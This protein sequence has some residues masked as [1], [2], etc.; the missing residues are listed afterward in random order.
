M[1]AAGEDLLPPVEG[2]QLLFE[3]DVPAFGEAEPALFGGGVVS[4]GRC[5]DGPCDLVGDPLVLELPYVGAQGRA[6][7]LPVVDVAVVA[8]DPLLGGVDGEPSVILLLDG[9]RR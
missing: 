6:L 5:Q 7:L 1:P 2:G 3:E 4:T 9:W 8:G